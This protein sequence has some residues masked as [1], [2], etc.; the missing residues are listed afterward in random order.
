M[1]IG[2]AKSASISKSRLSRLQQSRSKFEPL[3]EEVPM[4]TVKSKMKLTIRSASIEDFGIYTCAS[5]NNLGEADGTV[6]L[7]HNYA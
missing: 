5:K 3:T 7:Y 6:K 2:S 4:S 1:R